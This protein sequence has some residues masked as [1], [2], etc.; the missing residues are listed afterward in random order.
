LR[1][2]SGALAALEEAPIY[3][4][5]QPI[6]LDYRLFAEHIGLCEY[7]RPHYRGWYDA[8]M[9]RNADVA[10][11]FD[12]SIH[13]LEKRAPDFM[14]ASSFY[15][16]RY[17]TDNNSVEGEMF[18][19]L[20]A[21]DSVHH[22]VAEMHYEFLPWLDPLLEFINPTVRIFQRADTLAEPSRSPDLASP[23]E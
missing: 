12:L 2:L 10:R 17:R 1:D 5:L 14:I 4:L 7:R 22:Q 8:Q 23:K 11:N 3:Q 16:D 20:F 15:Y 18:D 6:Y 9:D 13:G 21:G 19:R